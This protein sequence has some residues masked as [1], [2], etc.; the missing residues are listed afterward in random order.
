MDAVVPALRSG[1]RLADRYRIVEEV[2]AGGMGRV[3]R[4]I[5]DASGDPVA[6]KIVRV[7]DPGDERRFEREATALGR[8]SHPAVVRYLGHGHERGVHYLVMEWLDGRTLREHLAE[9]GITPAESVVATA[10][11]AAG[12]AA[13]HARG[14]VHR[15]I[16]PGNLLL[17]GGAL[18][19][20]TIIDF[21]VARPTALR[22]IITHTGRAVG[23][24]GY[25]S[26]E[27]TRGERALDARSDVFSLGCVLYECLTGRAPFPGEHATAV[28]AKILLQDPPPLASLWREVPPALD[29]LVEACLSKDSRRRPVDGGD[30]ARR[31]AALPPLDPALPRRSR[32]H[33]PATLPARPAS[34]SSLLTVVLARPAG[35]AAPPALFDRARRL[36]ARVDVVGDGTI[37]IELATGDAAEHARALSSV[38]DALGP[39]LVAA[40]T[41]PAGPDTRAD[42]LERVART[43]E[44]EALVAVLP[45]PRPRGAVRTDE[46]TIALLAPPLEVVRARGAYLLP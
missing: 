40:A 9:R 30:L 5:D 17:V 13:V 32:Y 34:A 39:G 8:V 19:R 31:L 28:C 41:A 43:F 35:P 37:V 27:Q 1:D 24:P 12:L 33:A 10:R 29:A 42:V 25:M 21:G 15:D 26:P 2:G 14:L 4:A 7:A 22:E 16:K 23:T 3:Y 44:A 6:I 36:G 20:V 45:V 18:E 38:V 46:A 11:V